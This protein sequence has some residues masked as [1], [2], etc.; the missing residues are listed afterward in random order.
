MLT[1]FHPRVT[2]SPPDIPD[3]EKSSVK[4]V[5]FE[6]SN[7]IAASLASALH[8]LAWNQDKKLFK[9]QNLIQIHRPI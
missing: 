8:P 9:K 6:G 5:M 2:W 4:T 3:P 7:I 1:S